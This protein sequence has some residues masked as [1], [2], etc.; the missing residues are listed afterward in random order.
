MQTK[1]R[2]TPETVSVYP[3]DMDKLNKDINELFHRDS[4]YTPD[5]EFSANGIHA[6]IQSPKLCIIDDEFVGHDISDTITFFVYVSGIHEDGIR[7]HACQPEHEVTLTI[8][9][10]QKYFKQQ[11]TLAEFT[12]SRRGYNTRI[13]ANEADWIKYLNK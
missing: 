12:K 3:I 4:K 6:I 11:I 2:Y 9:E 5:M 8:T 10:L 13:R 1:E 7:W